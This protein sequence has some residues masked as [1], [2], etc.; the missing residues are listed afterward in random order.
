M[1]SNI[2]S[3]VIY[4][5]IAFVFGLLWQQHTLKTKLAESRLEAAKSS[6]AY[7][8]ERT[9][10][11]EKLADLQTKYRNM[12][13][14][15]QR[16]SNRYKEEKNEAISIATKQRNDLLKR[17]R[18]AEANARS[19]SATSNMSSSTGDSSNGEATR[20]SHIEELPQRIGAE[21]V[22]EAERAE[23]IRLNLLSCYRQ[24]DAV[25]DVMKNF[26]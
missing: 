23:V 8:E 26:R 22:A 12:E 5:L 9:R 16:E 19:R 13:S 4:L 14:S 15:L 1:L 24:Y 10:A 6:E 21:D 17:L 3:V 11:A 25:V 20:G 18:I 7:A 2:K